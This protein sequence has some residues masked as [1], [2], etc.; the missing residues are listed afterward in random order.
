MTYTEQRHVVIFGYT[1]REM[2]RVLTHFTEALPDYVSLSFTTRSLATSITLV[3]KHTGQEM[4][5]FKMNRLHRN[6][7][8]I[9]HEEVIA[10]EDVS[11]PEILAQSLAEKEL[12]VACAESCTGGNLAHSMVKLPG[13][14]SY[15][16]GSVVS[17]SNDV[18]AD[19]LKVPRQYLDRFGAVSQQ[20]VEAMAKG[21]STLMNA[22]CSMATS[23]IAGPDGGTRFKPVGT[24]WMAVKYKDKVVSE[25]IRFSGNRNEVIESATNHVMVMLIKVLRNSYIMQEDYNDE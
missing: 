25:C 15:F 22:D 9:F 13:S 2:K 11:I 10:T 6:L 8:D 4:L 24:V 17:Y 21:V 1:Q 7:L 16:L 23:G 20:V 19:V 14:S 12:T 3:G 5:R 18:K